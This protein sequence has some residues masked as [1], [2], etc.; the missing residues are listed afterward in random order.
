M[1]NKVISIIMV[2]VLFVSNAITCEAAGKSAIGLE[3]N[4]PKGNSDAQV[5]INGIKSKDSKYSATYKSPSYV[6]KDDFYAKNYTIKYWSSH[7]N[8]LGKLW[9][10]VM[11][12][13]LIYLKR[14][15]LHG[16]VE[17]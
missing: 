9:G 13:N 6:K 17:I 16:Q 3:N 7:G 15:I 4:A 10:L 14:R 11:T 12:S 8:N 2:F 5:F 1:R